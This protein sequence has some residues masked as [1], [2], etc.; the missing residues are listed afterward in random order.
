HIFNFLSILSPVFDFLK[1]SHEDLALFNEICKKEYF[2]FNKPM[3]L[4]IIL[5]NN[6]TKDHNEIQVNFDSMPYGIV[7]NF[8]P[9]YL[10]IQIDNSLDHYFEEVFIP[11]SQ[12]LAE[13]SDN[14]IKLLNTKTL[15]KAHKEWLI[16]NNKVKI[17]LITDIH[18]N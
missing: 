11:S 8:S 14:F 6:E 4:Q 12:N 1:C 15:S 16:K 13:N 7:Q 9:E 17:D 18:A 5:L 3:I 10:K 2:S